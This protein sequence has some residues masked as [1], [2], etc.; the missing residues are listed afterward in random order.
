MKKFFED[1]EHF[2]QK[3]FGEKHY[4]NFGTFNRG[5]QDVSFSKELFG[6]ETMLMVIKPPMYYDPFHR[7]LY[8][9]EGEPIRFFLYDKE[10]DLIVGCISEIWLGTNWQ[11]VLSYKIITAE[12]RMKRSECPECG[13]WL[14]ER[15]NKSGHLFMGCSGFPDCEF[16]SEIDKIYDDEE[17]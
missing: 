6:I 10:T 17:Y 7:D 8:A 4:V 14:V 9:L 16:S 13:F 11:K 1:F 2:I 5:R 12:E 15:M 3:V